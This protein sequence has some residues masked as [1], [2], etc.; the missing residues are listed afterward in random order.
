M[1]TTLLLVAIASVALLSSGTSA[2][3]SKG[4]SVTVGT[5]ITNKYLASGTGSTL[6]RDPALQSDL[7]VMFP[8]GFYVDLWNSR[9]LRGSWDDGSLGNEVDYSVGWKG[10]VAEGASLNVATSYFDEPRA[11][12]LGKGDILYTR[13]FLT[14]GFKLLPVTIGYENYVAM[15]SSGFRGGSLVSLGSG[16]SWSGIESKISARVSAAAVYDFGTLGTSSGVIFRGGAGIDWKASKR[17]TVNLIGANWF[18][19]VTPRDK[20]S[21]DVAFSTGVTWSVK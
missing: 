7:F 4:P 18:V 16:K 17:L 20:R 5:L 1:K 9:S 8:N 3:E 21:S 14:K 6:S 13:A 12:D 11:F 10:A 15:P 2:S 19:P